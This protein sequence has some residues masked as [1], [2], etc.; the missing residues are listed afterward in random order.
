MAVL[1]KAGDHFVLQ[2][3]LADAERGLQVQMTWDVLLS[4]LDPAGNLVLNIERGNIGE[5]TVTIFN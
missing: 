5:T 4:G 3:P 1:L 2:Q